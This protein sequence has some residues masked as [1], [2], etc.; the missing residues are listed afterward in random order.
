[1]TGPAVG[2]DASSSRRPPVTGGRIIAELV[3]ANVFID[4]VAFVFARQAPARYVEEIA[5]AALLVTIVVNCAL[6]YVALLPLRTLEA[7]AD[8]V[9]RGDLRARVHLPRYADRD[10]AR[11]GT[12]LNDLLDTVTADRAR[13]RHLAAQVIRAGDAERAAIARELHDSTAQQL[14]ALD[15][16]LAATVRESTR[17][18]Y[19]GALGHRLG[20]M[21]EIVGEAIH[22]VRALAHS[23]HPRLLEERGLTAALEA[24]AGRTRDATGVEVRVTSDAR[25]EVPPAIAATL[26]RVA[27]EAVG[28][29]VRHA[30]ARTV[31][32]TVAVDATTAALAVEDDGRGFDLGASGTPAGMG[33]FTMRERAALVGGWVD[34]TSRSG[35][36]AR[37]SIRVPLASADEGAA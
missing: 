35:G 26:Y 14:A 25:A 19:D 21:Q 36:G 29:A 7:T 23:V 18:G 8:R 24:L 27:Q 2:P 31:H 37:V 3:L 9:A 12:A 30:A 11:V 5:A 34:V 4:S 10:L 32:V 6:I 20:V 1:M 15:L 17:Q 16:L 22:E 13:V 28:N 33:L